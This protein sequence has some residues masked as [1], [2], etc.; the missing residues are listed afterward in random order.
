MNVDFSN[1][2]VSILLISFLFA[3]FYY[4]ATDLSVSYGTTLDTHGTTSFNFTSQISA[5]V[6]D[7]VT[8]L[9]AAT[10]NPLYFFVLVPDAFRILISIITLP[11][12]IVTT[13][14]NVILVVIPIPMWAVTFIEVALASTFI[15]TLIALILRYR[16]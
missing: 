8:D 1:V 14:I 7:A 3:G 12:D 15:F 4:V 16:T 11:Y 10:I 13:F 5:A 6:S 9:K 2:F